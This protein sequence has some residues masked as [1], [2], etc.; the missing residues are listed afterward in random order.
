MKTSNFIK[1][2][3]SVIGVSV[4]IFSALATSK[5][6]L[7]EDNPNNKAALQEIRKEA[8]VKEAIITEADVLHI[9]VEEDGTRRDGY[10]QYI[11]EIL[12]EHHA[13]TNWVKVV[14]VGSTNDPNKDNAYGVLIGESHC[15]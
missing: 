11:C 2:L 7:P 5:K 1:N 9:S 15:K 12:R 4:L 8:K 13:T 6:E 14:R 3:F 10:A